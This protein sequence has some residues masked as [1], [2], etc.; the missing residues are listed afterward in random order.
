MFCKSCHGTID[1]GDVHYELTLIGSPQTK[2]LRFCGW[3]CFIE[4]A[5]EQSVPMG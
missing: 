4:W 5:H 2:P 1:P 3:E